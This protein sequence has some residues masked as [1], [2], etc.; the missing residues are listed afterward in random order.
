MLKSRIASEVERTKGI[1]TRVT[2]LTTAFT[3]PLA[4]RRLTECDKAAVDRPWFR[5]K[6]EDQGVLLL[7]RMFT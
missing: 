1:S 3:C 2:E 5:E 4:I 7:R 6:A